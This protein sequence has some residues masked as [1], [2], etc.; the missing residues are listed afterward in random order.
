MNQ[1][2]KTFIYFVGEVNYINM[3]YFEKLLKGRHINL[4]GA[5]ILSFFACFVFITE[6]FSIIFW[7]EVFLVLINLLWWIWSMKEYKNLK[8]IEEEIKCLKK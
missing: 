5:L 7:I 2:I 8:R 4:I 6:G 1:R 3:G